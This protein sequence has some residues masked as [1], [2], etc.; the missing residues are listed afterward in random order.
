MDQAQLAREM[1]RDPA[2]TDSGTLRTR[3]AEVMEGLEAKIAGT[4]D[5]ARPGEI[6][7]EEAESL[8]QL[9]GAY[10]GVSEAVADFADSANK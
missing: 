10:R 8:Y 6:E 1:A 3:L 5:T 7:T 2:Y 4:L 9:L